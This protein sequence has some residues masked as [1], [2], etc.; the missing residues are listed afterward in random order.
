MERQNAQLN[1]SKKN[2]FNE[3]NTFIIEHNTK[4]VENTIK[5]INVAG[6]NDI[7]SEQIK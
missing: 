7:L 5:N 1:M 3:I 2:L 6:M 4:K